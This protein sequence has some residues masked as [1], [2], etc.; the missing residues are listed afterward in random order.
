MCLAENGRNVK[1]VDGTSYQILYRSPL[2][3]VYFHVQIEV[4]ITYDIILFFFYLSP[5]SQ[6]FALRETEHGWFGLVIGGIP[7]GKL[8]SVKTFR[9]RQG[10]IYGLL[11]VHRVLAL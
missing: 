2:S 10:K 8:E 11:L 3:T 7:V 5:S 6:T 9:E 1:F 4:P